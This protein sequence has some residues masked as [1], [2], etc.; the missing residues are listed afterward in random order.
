[1]GVK[2]VFGLLK[3]KGLGAVGDFI[4]NFLPAFAL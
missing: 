2:P 3:D 4:G 1:L